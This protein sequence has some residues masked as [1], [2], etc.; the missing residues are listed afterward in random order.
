MEILRLAL[1]V[2]L[3]PLSGFG[4]AL[5]KIPLDEAQAVTVV[6]GTEVPTTCQF[7]GPIAGLEVANVSA[8]AEDRPPVL[9]SHQAGTSFFSVRAL[10]AASRAA[11]NV[12][13]GGKVY[14]LSFVVG[15]DPDRS[16]VFVAA[17]HGTR[18]DP[19]LVSR[20]T[21]AALVQ[22]ARRWTLLQA[23]QPALAEEVGHAS[24][25]TATDYRDFQVQ[26]EE[27]WRFGPEDAL[28][29]R[30]RLVNRAAA[31]LRVDPGVIAIRVGRLVLPLQAVEGPTEIAPRETGEFWGACLGEGPASGISVDNEFRV[32]V[33]RAA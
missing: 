20:V 29:F 7:P 21:P 28:V 9:L 19:S 23:Q 10:G 12:I 30:L 1:I 4:A 15:A 2:L 22:R 5:R 6:I 17:S 26:V 31:L 16:V 25:R 18:V 27:V 32:I 8:R 33:P 14:V 3:L 24:P 13:F 11:A